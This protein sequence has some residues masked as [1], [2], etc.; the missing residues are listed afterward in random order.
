[1]PKMS[2]TEILN[3]LKTTE[4]GQ[5][6]INTIS[7]GLINNT[8][9]NFHQIFATLAKSNLQILL[10]VS[11]YTFEQKIKDPGEFNLN[12]IDFMADLFKVEFEVMLHF[13]HREMMKA[14]T[15]KAHVKTKPLIA[16]KRRN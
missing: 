10:S 4:K 11:F 5:H 13:V 3:M 15:K 6:I 8:T 9:E 12:E 2:K 14:K 16:S 1:M 7:S